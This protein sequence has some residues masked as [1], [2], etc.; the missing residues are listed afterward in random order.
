[1]TR[2]NARMVVLAV[3]NGGLPE[4]FAPLGGLTIS[5]MQVARRL[6]EAPHAGDGGWRT[7]L[8]AAG[9][10][11]VSLSATGEY[12]G[13]PAEDTLI[14]RAMD[15]AAANWRMDFG[16][17]GTLTVPCIVASYEREA[18]QRGVVT[19]RVTV[20]SAGAGIYVAA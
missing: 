3:G 17:A 10:W 12:S 16:A 18:E 20:E 6:P 13:S 19:Y 14:A 7:L 8:P 15:G 9:I 4:I 2:Q 1:M 5:R 11:Q